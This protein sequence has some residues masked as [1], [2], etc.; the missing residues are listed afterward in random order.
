MPSPPCPPCAYPAD[1]ACEA[2]SSM[3]WEGPEPRPQ[4]V[5]TLPLCV[6]SQAIIQLP[7]PLTQEE[8]DR[9]ME[10]LRA[11][12]PGLTPLPLGAQGEGEPR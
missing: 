3:A 8:W 11:M 7:Q 4:R 6:G 9:M 10:I 12:K 5:F 2:G 1:C